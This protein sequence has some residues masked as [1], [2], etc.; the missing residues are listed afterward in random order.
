[1]AYCVECGSDISFVWH[2]KK[3]YTKN[4]MYRR[5]ERICLECGKIYFS[6]EI[7]M[8][9]NIE[10]AE[11]LK[12]VKEYKEHYRFEKIKKLETEELF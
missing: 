9:D 4:Y 11:L 2:T 1:M 5:R 7:N 3:L 12:V 8:P 10:D 6:I